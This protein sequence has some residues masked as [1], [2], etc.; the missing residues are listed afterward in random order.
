MAAAPPKKKGSIKAKIAEKEAQKVAKANDV[1]Y[2]SDDVLDPK[3]KARRDKEREL[4][5][6]LHNAVDLLGAGALGGGSF[7]SFGKLCVLMKTQKGRR[8]LSSIR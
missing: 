4:K 3:E 8:H 5:S 7:C 6:D 1:E 2:D